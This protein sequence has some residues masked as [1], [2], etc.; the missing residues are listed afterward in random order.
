MLYYKQHG[1]NK[2]PCIILHG[3]LGLS[4][5]W[6]TIAKKLTDRYT[7]Y[8][9]DIRNHGKSAH[10]AS[11]TYIEMANDIV[12]FI[13]EQNLKK[14]TIIG[15]SMGGKI[16]MYLGKL[17]SD[18]LFKLI[19]IDISPKN[20]D[21]LHLKQHYNI[22]EIMQNT[23]LEKFHDRASLSK[24]IYQKIKDS[25]IVGLILKNIG[26][27]T[28]NKYYWKPNL[29]SIKKFLPQIAGGFDIFPQIEVPTL[30]VK[31]NNTSYIT[32][33]D[34]LLIKNIF[35]NSV[36]HTIKNTGHWIHVEQPMVL[37]NKIKNF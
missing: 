10:Y 32:L 12:A 16:A 19:I 33:N 29:Q 36:I 13:R 9:I 26:R 1:E 37:I 6:F 11:M 7:V 34:E 3:L 31:A 22:I 35:T 28:Q 25:S 17:I 14:I 4:D 30:F 21:I 18:N 15:H 8:T 20:Y 23:P 5:N 27:K 24:Y 2:P